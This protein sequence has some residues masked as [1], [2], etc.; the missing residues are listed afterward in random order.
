LT[1]PYNVMMPSQLT[2]DFNDQKV[3]V[4]FVDGITEE[5]LLKMVCTCDEHEACNG[6][7]YEALS[8]DRPSFTKTSEACWTEMKYINGCE[9]IGDSH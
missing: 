6:V 4:E 8:S 2:P 5:V 1:Q 9:P 7:V 3:R